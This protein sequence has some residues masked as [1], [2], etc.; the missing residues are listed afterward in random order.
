MEGHTPQPRRRRS[1][2]SCFISTGD[3]LGIV[4]SDDL[5]LAN[6]AG[7]L[8][9]A[10]VFDVA[11]PVAI[12][13]RYAHDVRERKLTPSALVNQRA[14]VLRKEVGACE[15]ARLL[16]S[17]PSI[18]G[19]GRSESA[20]VDAYVPVAAL[21]TDTWHARRDQN[22]EAASGVR[23]KGQRTTLR[24]PCPD[25]DEPDPDAAAWICPDYVG[26]YH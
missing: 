5:S 20:I 10:L 19:P 4:V 17:A 26:A 22:Q 25:F 16:G 3:A 12:L 6:L 2:A 8:T 9:K 14:P 15:R 23:K 13:H 21:Q 18:K 11:T 7:Y 1:E 24:P